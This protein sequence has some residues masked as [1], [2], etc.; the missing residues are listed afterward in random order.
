MRYLRISRDKARLKGRAFLYT[1]VI[2]ALEVRQEDHELEA[3]PGYIVRP[4][5]KNNNHKGQAECKRSY[6]NV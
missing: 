3:N 6:P 5:L 2:P 1:S 4:C